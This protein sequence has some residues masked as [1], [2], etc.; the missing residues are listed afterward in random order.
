MA[1][2]GAAAAQGAGTPGVSYQE[3]EEVAPALARQILGTRSLT[4]TPLTAQGFSAQSFGTGGINAPPNAEVIELARALRNDP[5]L[6]Y[7]YVR[8]QIKFDPTYGAKRGAVATILDGFG[9]AF[10]QAQL[11]I[12]LLRE[13]GFTASYV[14]GDVQLPAADIAALTSIDSSTPRAASRYFTDGGIPAATATSDGTWEGTLVF[15]NLTTVWV[16][17][18]IGGTDFVFDPSLVPQDFTPSIDLAT[19]MGYDRTTFLTNALAGATQT[20]D[21][22][23]NV[24]RANVRGGLQSLATN[25]VSHIETN[26]PAATLEEI[27]GGGRPQPLTG[28]VRQ[29]AHPNELLIA[30]EWAGDIPATYHTLF[31]IQHLGIDHTFE[32][33][34][35]YGKRLTIFYDGLNQPVLR[36][37]GT[38]IATGTPGTLDAFE[39]IT[40]TADHPYASLGGTFMDHTVTHQIKV[41]GKFLV[42]NT[43]GLT[44]RG[45]LEKYRKRLTEYRHAGGAEG[46]EEV[47]G[48]GLA[49]LG[50]SWMAQNSLA[51]KISNAVRRL[52]KRYHHRIGIIGETDGPYIDLP[53]QI[54][55]GRGLD[56]NDATSVLG[57]MAFFSSVGVGS[58]LEHGTIEQNQPLEAVSTIKMLDLANTAGEQIFDATSAN[59]AAIQPQLSGYSAGT[60]A[61]IQ[62]NIDV[63]WRFLLPQNGARPVG[64]W[65]GFGYLMISA[66]ENTIGYIIGGGLKGGFP[67]TAGPFDSQT[68]Q[69]ASAK[70]D[71]YSDAE[72]TLEPI[73]LVTG[74]YL[75]DHQ[76]IAIGSGAAP[77]G[78]GFQRLY[79]SAQRLQD[80]P[81]GLGWTHNYAITATVDSNGF[82]GMGADSPIDA[83]AAIA[84]V[85]VSLDLLE[86]SKAKDRLLIVSLVDRWFMDLNTNNLVF[87]ARPG[88]DGQFVELADGSFNPPPGV[89]DA[90]TVDIDG[91]YILTTVDGVVADFD[92]SGRLEALT[93]PNG[94]AT[95]LTYGG[96]GEL[97]TVS[98][99][100]GRTLTLTYTAGRIT[101]VA[102]GTGRSVAYGYDAAGNLTGFTNA[103]SDATTF[104]YDIDGRMTKIFYPSF[105]LTPFV[106]N[107]YDTLDR[108]LTQTDAANNTW[109]YFF[110]GSRSEEVDP[111]GNTK[112]WIFDEQ[113]NTLEETDALGN[114]V[115]NVY[116]GQNRLI[117][118]TLPELNATATVYDETNHKPL[119]IT[120]ISKT[121]I[122]PP[123]VQSFTYEPNFNR[124]A[125]ST[126]ARGN[127]TD[128]TYDANGNLQTAGQP[129][130]DGG[131]TRPTTS[132]TYTANGQVE[133][134]TDAEGMVTRNTYDPVTG[135]LLTVVV[136]DGGLALTTD[137][138]YDAVGNRTSVTDRR[139][140]T[141]TSI[142]D[143]ERR[144]T[145]TTSP[146][147]FSFVTNQFYDPDGRVLRVERQTDDVL[148]PWQ[149]T[150]SSYFPSGKQQTATDPENSVTTFA[151]DALLRLMRTT[152]AEGRITEREYDAVGRLFQVKQV[153]G[154]Q[155]VVVEEHAYTA[156]GLGQSV[157]DAE[158]SQT[159]FVYDDH[160]RL[161]RTVYADTSFEQRGY[162]D[163]RNLTSLRTR[164]GDSITFTYDAL[165]RRD[166]KTLPDLTAIDFDYDLANRT[167]AVTSSAEVG[168]FD[169]LYDTAG[170]L[171]QVTR[172]DLKTVGYGYDANGN[173]TR[174]DYPDASF[175]TYVYD[176]LGRLKEVRDGGVT[177]LAQYAYD[178]LSR[179]TSTTYDNGA[180]TTHAY[181]LDDDLSQ[182][183]QSYGVG[184]VTF[185]YLYNLVN[186]RTDTSV[187]DNAYLWLPDLG[188]SNSYLPNALN[189]YDDV[190][191]VLFSYDSNGNLTGDG[192]N[193][194]LYDVESRL[195]SATTPLH[196]AD[197]TYDPFGRRAEKDVDA[198]VTKF[199]YAGD[200]VIAEYDGLDQLQARY[201]PGPGIDKPVLM[202]RG[203]TL[204]YY[205]Y[206]G[207]GSVVAATDGF[208][209]V[210]ET[211]AYGAY[212]E[213]ADGDLLGNPFRYTGRRL[214]T[215]TGLYYYRAR[216]YSASLGRFL[217]PDPAGFVDGLNLYAYVRNDPLNLVDPLG[218]ARAGG[219]LSGFGDALSNYIS[220]GF[221]ALRDIPGDIA[222]DFRRFQRDKL[223]FAESVFKSIPVTKTAATG[224]AVLGALKGTSRMAGQLRSAAIGKGNFGIGSATR[225]EA[226][227]M[228]KAWV[229]SGSRVSSNGKALISKDGLRQYRPPSQKPELGKTQ[230]NFER[231]FPGQ[232]TKEWQSN[233]HLDIVD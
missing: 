16:K 99:N 193:S 206:D 174:L 122:L 40:Y 89:A 76:D 173:R 197:Y 134:H 140:N 133:T 228:G 80:G 87:V 218:L 47:L 217:Q 108:V 101:Q 23:Q 149:I 42:V 162:D 1:L 169:Y 182:V 225:A 49:M 55:S 192:V 53:M 70:T 46:S 155:T 30:E 32:S 154:V 158:N 151:Y 18:N 202:D 230:A 20:A 178:P 62:A 96:G 132:F 167:L 68:A 28:Q 189:Q 82:Q 185:D 119:T 219:F 148:N 77:I 78:L 13:S 176:E 227:A 33:R 15:I 164:A 109:D 215:E 115:V 152:D 196:L 79:T 81:L 171:T 74:D 181:E 207:T 24:N 73:N 39:N 223:G 22:I 175:V 65:T 208:G 102:D 88:L 183:A 136:D 71:R 157:L 135:D 142:Y 29:T 120:Q 36:L 51:E 107:V 216:Y 105:P 121:G 26:A 220:T 210:A 48:E 43:W 123:I 231:R 201:V 41:G 188:A 129:S 195:I 66:T 113:G 7:E 110:A 224:I 90:L 60:L 34:E 114:T 118:R 4:A 214:D 37:N 45:L 95:T 124:V 67:T 21:F 85:Y 54:V 141:T 8:D 75:Y 92:L 38:T 213:S 117:S 31:R 97:A 166:I 35:T 143:G 44:G 61:Q 6:I 146:A 50:Q 229:G 194:Y 83:A 138:G 144:P 168:S 165:N 163:N 9:N 56:E 5:D 199:V 94:N 69:D 221:N 170:R 198:T 190:D 98:N 177:L 200:T 112:I 91:S 64:D 84:A 147:P 11:M 58:A 233:G 93:D 187:D 191:G 156:N 10:D 103:E 14:L 52:A 222:R 204:S 161:F 186:Q 180:Q 111:L 212:G 12:E 86:T 211:Y 57:P 116:D 72:V 3:G 17:V 232:T 150:Q 209:T 137:F 172:P 226:D 203:G 125:T 25:L 127:T 106:T 128:F 139:G 184:S 159:T 100:F 104:E 59:Y 205:H 2:P 153:L 145:Q 131:M 179:V 126:D 130:L 160:D 19:A 27:I 63:G